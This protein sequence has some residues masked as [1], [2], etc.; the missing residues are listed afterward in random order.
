[1]IN[2]LFLRGDWDCRT[3][4]SI[5]DYDD[6]WIQ[7]FEEIIGNNPATIFF[8]SNK[9]RYILKNNYTIISG[10]HT[11]LYK[12]L[13]SYSHVFS[14]GGFEWQ[15]DVLRRVS[16][17]YTIRYGAGKR[18]M[19]E[20]DINYNLVLVDSEE[21]QTKVKMI[22]PKS[23]PKLF[24][25]PAAKHFVPI[26]CKKEYDV[27][28]IAKSEQSEF[29]GVDWVYRTAPSDLKILHLGG[30]EEFGQ[31]SNIT[32]KRVDRIDMPKWISKCKIG[33]VPYFNKID[34]CPRVIS[35]M[36]ACGLPI[37]VSNELVYWG[38]KYKLTKSDKTGFWSM[39]KDC[40]GD[41]YDSESI[42]DG[43]WTTFISN[44][45]NKN[46]SIPVAANHIRNLI[47]GQ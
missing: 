24:I 41:I 47:E 28:Y 39:V 34:S 33:I 17:A 3:G 7:L 44:Y 46:L 23:N 10:Y 19:P 6:M 36:I 27:C 4:K 11:K 1:M 29:K 8:R 38:E 2:W 43:T 32:A 26:P 20:A 37:V 40:N 15:A 25:K 31:P 14:R 22:F 42:L 16:S 12:R 18:F 35:E 45:Y 21:Q 30:V 9:E 13:N 5:S